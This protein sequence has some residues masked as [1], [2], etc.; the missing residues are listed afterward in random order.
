MAHGDR[1][2]YTRFE[3]MFDEKAPL[4]QSPADEPVA[5]WTTEEGVP[6]RLVWRA[7]RYRVQGSPSVWAELPAW[8]RPFGENRYGVGSLP[9]QIGGWRLRAVS[10]TG[11]TRVFDLRHDPGAGRWLLV[12]SARP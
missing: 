5:V 2:G 6:L 7:T 9:R 11:E 12:R 10:E 8:W 4:M 3:G 1:R